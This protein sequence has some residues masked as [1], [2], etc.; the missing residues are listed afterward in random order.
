MHAQARN[1]CDCGRRT[2]EI[3]ASHGAFGP[4]PRPTYRLKQDG[5]KHPIMTMNR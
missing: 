3:W 2:F 1:E 4:F 5:E